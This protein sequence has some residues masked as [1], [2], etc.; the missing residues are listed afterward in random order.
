MIIIPIVIRQVVIII[1]RHRALTIIFITITITFII[2]IAITILIVRR[3][4]L[5]MQPSSLTAFSKFTQGPSKR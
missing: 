3:T 4:E 5:V 2:T 1:F